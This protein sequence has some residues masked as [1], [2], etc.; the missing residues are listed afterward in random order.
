MDDRDGLEKRIA[1]LE[2]RLEEKDREIDRLCKIEEMYHIVTD[3]TSDVLW[4]LNLDLSH[5]YISPAIKDLT[6]YTVEE[7]MD[8]PFG[9]QLTTES[10]E[11]VY[12]CLAMELKN[13]NPEDFR[14][15][16]TMELEH[17]RR[18]G[19]TF[20]AEVKASFIFD[21]K[22]GVEGIRGV[23]RD[24]TQKRALEK[25]FK[26]A[27][28]TMKV[29]MDNLPSGIAIVGRDRRIRTLNQAALDIMG[30]TDASKVIGQVCHS[31]IC[32]EQEG[33]CPILDLGQ[34]IDKAERIV[35]GPGNKAV[36]VFKTVIPIKIEGEDVLLESF[37]D[38]T[39]QRRIQKDLKESEQMFRTYTEDSPVAVMITKADGALIYV[40]P[41]ASRVTGY[42]QGQLLHMDIMDV[43]HPAF[44]QKL[45]SRREKR[46]AGQAT[47]TRYEV[48]INPKDGSVMWADV[49]V[50]VIEYRGAS[51]IMICSVDITQKKASDLSLRQREEQ[52]R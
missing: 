40:N 15:C 2:K 26:Q 17:K 35:L 28:N 52:Y 37:I 43:I 4:I 1:A 30:I 25:K 13:A 9:D 3:N 49:S 47:E 29:V 21:D 16:V 36:P 20:W 14:R 50:R 39:E 22:G 23:T 18:D 45:A 27:F 32:P 46:L 44:H 33:Q 38:I 41:E 10:A 11:R 24:I 7:Y 31:R 19:T 51:A 5:R 12:N 34:A 6:G 48:Q 8:L 42:T